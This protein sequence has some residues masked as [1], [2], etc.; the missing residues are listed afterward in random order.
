MLAKAVSYVRRNHLA[1]LALFVALG[2]A[3][4]AAN[5]IRSADIVDGQ[6]KRPDLSGSPT[7]DSA[8]A[9][10]NPKIAT[11]AV[12]GRTLAG[13]S[14]TG[15]KVA[16]D[17]LQG[18]DIDETTLAQVF[19][20]KVADN[21]FNANAAFSAQ[22][23]GSADLASFANNSDKVDGL[24]VRTLQWDVPEGS[25]GNATLLN[26]HGLQLTTTSCPTGDAN[27]AFSILAFTDT[28]NS[29]LRKAPNIEPDQ[30]TDFDRSTGAVAI[31][32]GSDS[33]G[34][35]LVVYH[36]GTGGVVTV[37]LAWSKTATRCYVFGTVLGG[38]GTQDPT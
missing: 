33:D 37:N 25:P 22:S 7:N 20:A 14:V 38:S 16:P 26:L 11:G 18:A 10:T 2:P 4:Y 8:R 3:A 29:W 13:D 6:V 36:R 23:A 32:P 35:A 1:L 15:S 30:V 17:S 9:V 27:G 34:S 21:A 19:S 5:T 28:D 31:K 12:N 24:H